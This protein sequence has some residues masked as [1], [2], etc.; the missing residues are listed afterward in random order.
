MKKP[1]FDMYE[2][3]KLTEETPTVEGFGMVFKGA[4]GMVTQIKSLRPHD[5]VYWYV[6]EVEFNKA[7]G[8][9]MYVE[10]KAERL[11]LT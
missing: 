9:Y 7:R 11:E 10:V 5:G 4:Q 6:V 3:V 8:E 2:L 1:A